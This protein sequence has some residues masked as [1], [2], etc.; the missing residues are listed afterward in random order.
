MH[1]AI[2]LDELLAA[3]G[4]GTMRL[5]L[6]LEQVIT[7]TAGTI[8]GLVAGL[9]AANA[10]LGRIP[11]FAEPLVTPPL[12]H[13]VA[14]APVALVTGAALL[15]SLL[16]ALGVSELLLRGIRVERLREAPS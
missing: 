9:L 14:A 16:C 10:A 4:G 12:P 15:A 11:Q 7:M 2:V 8:A 13:E 3:A 6:L 1:L 5:A